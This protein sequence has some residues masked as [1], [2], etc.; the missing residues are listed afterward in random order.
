MPGGELVAER[1]ARARGGDRQQRRGD[2]DDGQPAHAG[3]ARLWSG[4]GQGLADGAVGACV[5]AQAALHA[6]G[7]GDR[8][9]AAR[10][11]GHQAQ[12]RSVGAEEPAVGA[13][14]E[15]ARDHEER[16]G[17][18]HRRRRAEAEDSDEGVFAA[19]GEAG[20]RG[21]VEHRVA[22][23]QPGDDAEHVVEPAGHS[24]G[25]PEHELLHRTERAD[26][27]A[28][29]AAG[30]QRPEERNGEER[31]NRRGDRHARIGETLRHVLD[32]A[33]RA[34]ATAPPEAEVRRGK[35]RQRP[36]AP[37]RARSKREAVGQ[38]QRGDEHG[39]IEVRKPRRAG[40][41]R[42]ERGRCVAGLE[43]GTREALHRE[44]RQRHRPEAGAQQEAMETVSTPRHAALP[45]GGRAGPPG[46]GGRRRR[47]RRGRSCIRCSSRSGRAAPGERSSRCRTGRSP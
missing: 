34:D 26:G 5:L 29:G 21:G 6:V 43:V 7:G 36:E 11:A 46:R 14:D 35:Q 1:E 8:Q 47:G 4:G 41:G 15:E 30:E 2:Q 37:A 24:H 3:R 44:Q 18:G 45:S 12:Q 17:D 31:E 20:A 32:R 9:M 40:G 16:G 13:A 10:H 38:R 33:H 22:E 39:D 42:G 19:D 27:R 23:V 25:A 28:E